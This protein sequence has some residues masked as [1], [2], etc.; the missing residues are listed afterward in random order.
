PPSNTFDIRT[1]VAAPIVQV[2]DICV[3]SITLSWTATAND[4]YVL[5][6]GDANGANFT[7]IAASIPA[8]QTTFTDTGLANGTYT[9]RVTGFSVFPDGNDSAVSN[10]AKAT[11]GPINISHVDP[12][13]PTAPGF[14][15]SS[16][17]QANG[18]A[19]FSTDEHLLRL[20]NNFGQAGSAFTVQQV[21]I[22]GFATTF[23]IRLHEGT[24]PNPAD[25]LTFT[26][27]PNRPTAVGFGGGS[28]G[29]QGIGRSVAIKFDVW[30][31]EGETDNST[32]LF[33]NGSF[34]GLAHNPGEVNVPIDKANVNLRSQSVKTITLT[35]NGVSHT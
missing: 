5:E 8:S 1:R 23:Q 13:N 10:V 30:N 31:N 11:I 17:M 35:Y 34:P 21:G 24:Q 18:S 14:F 4:H 26:L 32:G 12:T 15:D 3:G 29:F 7:V 27:Q 6:R 28:L 16:D 33:F 19:F 20:N 25:G 22:R 2:T 9:Y